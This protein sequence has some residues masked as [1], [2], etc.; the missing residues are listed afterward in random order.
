MVQG[1]VDGIAHARRVRSAGDDKLWTFSTD[2]SLMSF[3][4]PKGSVAIDGVS[5]TI[6]NVNQNTFTVALIPTTLLKTTLG[7]LRPG[8]RVNVETDI[9][10]RTI[11]ATLQRW[12]TE[13]GIEPLTLEVLQANGW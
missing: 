7:S 4:I 5:L 12:R 9:V 10:V 3:I 11:V 6:A 13:P 1:H 8:D 2:T